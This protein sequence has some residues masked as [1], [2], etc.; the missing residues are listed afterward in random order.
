[1]KQTLETRTLPRICN[2][3]GIADLPTDLLVEEAIA[4][5]AEAL[6][7]ALKMQIVA[8]ANQILKEGYGG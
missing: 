3:A 4:T 5:L 8:Y 2:T 6:P 1:M 7:E